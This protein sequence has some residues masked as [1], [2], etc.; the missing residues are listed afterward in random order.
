MVNRKRNLNQAV[1]ELRDLRKNVHRKW[2]SY[3]NHIIALV[4]QGKKDMDAAVEEATQLATRNSEFP[5][6]WV[7]RP[8]DDFE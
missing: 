1:R 3:I 7:G 8:D 5:D 6:D 2:H 4:E